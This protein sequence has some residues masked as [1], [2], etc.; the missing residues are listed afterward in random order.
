MVLL[1]VVDATANDEDFED[2]HS[3]V[4]VELIVVFAG[5]KAVEL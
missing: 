5:Y 1:V 3:G 2:A 4:L